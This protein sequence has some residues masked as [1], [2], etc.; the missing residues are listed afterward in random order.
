[1]FKWR[2]SLAHHMK[3][4]HKGAPP[5]GDVAHA[6]LQKVMV[7]SSPGAITDV[8]TATNVL[9]SRMAPYTVVESPAGS[10]SAGSPKN[11]DRDGLAPPH[12]R[13]TAGRMALPKPAMVMPPQH[14]GRMRE[15]MGDMPGAHMPRN[16]SPPG[17]IGSFYAGHNTPFP[18]HAAAAGQQVRDGRQ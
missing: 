2:S 16:V 7:P 9:S 17:I 13:M 11:D 18:G 8:R 10:S 12:A 1:M 6:A 14:M 3:T 5:A 4:K 15:P